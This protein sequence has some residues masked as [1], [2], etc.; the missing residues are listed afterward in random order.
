MFVASG[1][2]LTIDN[3]SQGPQYMKIAGSTTFAESQ[4]DGSLILGKQRDTLLTAIANPLHLPMVLSVAQGANPGVLFKAPPQGVGSVQFDYDGID[5][6]GMD[7]FQNPG[8]GLNVNLSGDDA[9]EFN[10]LSST[11]PLRIDVTAQSYNIFGPA[12]VQTAHGVLMVTGQVTLP[13]TFDLSFADLSTGETT[14]ATAINLTKI[15][16]IV[17]RITSMQTGGSFKL[18]AFSTKPILPPPTW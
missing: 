1:H 8:P 3:F 2:A 17:V 10:V 11:G 15:D 5:D 6:E 16:R 12:A 4:A 18:G 13:T 9:F 14:P 7:G